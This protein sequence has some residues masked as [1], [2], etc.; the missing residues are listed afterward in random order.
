MWRKR[1]CAISIN[2]KV[3]GQRIQASVELGDRIIA[4]QDPVIH[5][6][7]SHKRLDRVP[8]VFVHR[9]A[10]NGETL[11][12]VLLLKFGEPRNFD[13]ARATPGGPKIQQNHFAT[14]IGKLDRCAIFIF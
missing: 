4:E 6:V 5:F 9:D 13:D 8:T 7:L 1:H 2:D 14:V 11:R 12:F 10:K 3:R